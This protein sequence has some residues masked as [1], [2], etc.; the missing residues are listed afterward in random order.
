MSLSNGQ[1]VSHISDVCSFSIA[2]LNISFANTD[3]VCE[4]KSL[5]LGN[6]LNKDGVDIDKLRFSGT[7]W[8]KDG[9]QLTRNAYGKFYRL[10]PNGKLLES[11]Y[12]GG[13]VKKDISATRE[14]KNYQEH[15]KMRQIVV[16]TAAKIKTKKTTN[17]LNLI[18]KVLTD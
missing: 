12:W 5:S 13:S 10:L 7:G 14:L 1:V 3:L 9:N 6:L 16:K 18:A 2:G 17:L 8:T 15:L 4:R 11:A